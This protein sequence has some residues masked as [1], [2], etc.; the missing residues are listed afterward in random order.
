[1]IEAGGEVEGRTHSRTCDS[2]HECCITDCRWPE[3]GEGRRERDMKRCRGG[4][5]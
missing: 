2:E 1:M 3:E 4:D 5:Y